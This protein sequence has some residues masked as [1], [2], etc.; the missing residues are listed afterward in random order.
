MRRALPLLLVVAACT[1]HDRPATPS[2]RV[3]YRVV[4]GSGAVTTSTVDVS[5]PYRARSVTR[6][7]NGTVTGGF[8]WDK[9]GLYTITQTGSTQTAAVVPGFPGPYS[10]L[11]V[12]LPVAASQRLVR[13]A[14]RASVLDRPCT[15]WLSAEPLDGAPFAPATTQDRVTSCVTPDGIL[16]SETWYA[17]GRLIR[18][19]TATSAGPGPTLDGSALYGGTPTPLPSGA[20]ASTVTDASR[21]ELVRLMQVPAPHDPAG[22]APD[23]SVAVVDRDAAGLS[24]EGF[25]LTWRRG[26]Q[27]VVLRV[28][29]DLS[30][31]SKGTVRGAPVDLGVLGTGHLEPVLAGLRLVV[32]GPTGLRAIVTADLP[33]AE[34]LSWVRTLR[35][36]PGP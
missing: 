30:G 17:G 15:R 1:S 12:A 10:G 8:A 20:T 29:R 34:L 25:V 36:R 3:V 26:T 14:G 28:E 35:F 18:T 31:S 27:L 22:F 23:A 33:A 21:A 2:Q 32:D 19:R 7:A 6:D 5:P 11:A 16:L 24:R 4:D 13:S 9:R